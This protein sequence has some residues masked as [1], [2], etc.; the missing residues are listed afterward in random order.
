MLDLFPRLRLISLPAAFVRWASAQVEVFAN[1][2]KR[3][4]YG[5]GPFESSIV[6]RCVD[7]AT[8]QAAMVSSARVTSHGLAE[9]YSCS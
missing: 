2:F 5:N 8:S 1:I 7:T 6:Q 4:V 9:R 3:Q